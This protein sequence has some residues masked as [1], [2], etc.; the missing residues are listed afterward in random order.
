MLQTMTCLCCLTGLDKSPKPLHNRLLIASTEITLFKKPNIFHLP[1]I[2]SNGW[3]R[4][5]TEQHFPGIKWLFNQDCKSFRRHQQRVQD[6]ICEGLCLCQS[7]RQHPTWQVPVTAQSAAVSCEAAAATPQ[8]HLGEGIPA[9]QS[10]QSSPL[11][12]PRKHQP[13]QG[14]AGLLHQEWL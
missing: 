12:N 11:H 10:M 2:S 13:R 9:F 4:F 1:L 8:A 3:P 7:K 5:G 6:R 14:S